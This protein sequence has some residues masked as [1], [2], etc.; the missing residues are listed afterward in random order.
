MRWAVYESGSH[1]VESRLVRR[2]RTL[3]F[4]CAPRVR[5]LWIYTPRDEL[6][7]PQQWQISDS[8]LAFDN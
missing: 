7:R 6:L 4:L 5:N 2:M 1:E 8:F 3:G